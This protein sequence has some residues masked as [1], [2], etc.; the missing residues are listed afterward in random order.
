M[1][2]EIIHIYWEKY[3]QHEGTCIL[4]SAVVPFC[5]SWLY[6]GIIIPGL[7]VVNKG[8]RYLVLLCIYFVGIATG[9]GVD[10]PGIESR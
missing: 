9:Y 4:Q 5:C 1:F 3:I 2:R 6:I 10:G 8:D 7:Q